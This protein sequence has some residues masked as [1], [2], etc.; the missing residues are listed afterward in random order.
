MKEIWKDVIG[1]EGIY[2]V[3]SLGR[4]RR[5]TNKNKPKLLKLST[6][7]GYVRIPLY[8]ENK[9][10]RVFVHRLVAEAFI[11]NNYPDRIQVNHI[12]HIKDDN[13]IENLEWVTPKM[14][15]IHSYK[16]LSIDD[17]IKHTINEVFSILKTKRPDEINHRAIRSTLRVG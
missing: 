3:S 12:N 6:N 16:R 14:N 2:Q 9:R 11:P 10:E 8:K 1:Y 7:Q 15:S 13:Q 17:I 4:V 5:I